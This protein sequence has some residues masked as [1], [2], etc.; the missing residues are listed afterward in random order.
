MV[1]LTVCIGVNAIEM[2][3]GCG[4]SVGHAG[5]V[6]EILIVDGVVHEGFSTLVVSWTVIAIARVGF[7]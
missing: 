5:P 6:V 7:I 1:M 3:D 4:E 2:W